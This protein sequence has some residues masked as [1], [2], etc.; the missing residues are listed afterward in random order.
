M[1][2][3][4]ERARPIWFNALL[5][6]TLARMGVPDASTYSAHCL[7]IGA[8]TSAALQGASADEIKALGRWCSTAYRGYIRAPPRLP[9]GGP[10]GTLEG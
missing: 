8:A 3:S 4:G 6:A 2:P 5:K 9:P 10:S 7:R 1:L